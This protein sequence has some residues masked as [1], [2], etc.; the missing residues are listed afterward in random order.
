MVCQDAEFTQPPLSNVKLNCWICQNCCVAL[1]K[2]LNGLVKVFTCISRILPNT[3]AEI[4]PG[5]WIEFIRGK[6][7]SSK[8]FDIIQLWAAYTLRGNV[9]YLLDKCGGE[10][11]PQ[12]CCR[13]QLSGKRRADY[14][15]VSF[16]ILLFF[17]TE[18]SGL[19][20]VYPLGSLHPPLTTYS[21]LREFFDL[22]MKSLKSFKLPG[23][24]MDALPCTHHTQLGTISPNIVIQ[25]L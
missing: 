22:W 20:S 14:T 13:P 4:W 6:I 9:R 11:T 12:W 2:L 24:Y 17:M 21:P 16:K 10:A 23:T 3:Q 25:W 8:I 1:S 5:F 15:R 7:C 19:F 18:C